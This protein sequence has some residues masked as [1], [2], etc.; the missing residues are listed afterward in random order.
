M[1]I[2]IEERVPHKHILRKINKVIDFDFIYNEVKGSYGMNGNVSVAP[3]VILKLMLLL[4]LYNVRSERELMETLSVRLDWLW[5]LKLDIDSEI[6]DHSVLS[7]ARTRWGVEVFKCLFERVVGQCVQAG[8]VNGKKLFVDASLIDAD[9]SNNSVIK[10]GSLKRYLRKGYRKLEDRLDELYEEKNGEANKK[11]ISTTDPDAAVTRHSSGESKLRYKTHRGVDAKSE[12]ITATIVTTGSVDDGEKLGD[13]I[14]EHEQT[15]GC[16][17]DTVVGDSKYG[18]KRN[19]LM[20]SELGIKAHMPNLEK[21][22]HGKGRKKG[23]YPKE[24][25]NYDAVTDTFTCP[26]GKKLHKRNFYKK[27]QH[28]EYKAPKGEC[29]Q[30]HLKKECTRAKDGRTVKRHIRQKDLDAMLNAALRP[31][32]IQD[33]KT[34]QHL[35]ERSFARSTRYGFKR[36]R[37]RGLWRM[38]I[39]DYLIA[40]VQNIQ[41]LLKETD[42]RVAVAVR[43][44]RRVDRKVR[45]LIR[46]SYSDNPLGCEYYGYV[47]Q[48]GHLMKSYFSP[49]LY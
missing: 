11:Y 25:F 36:A 22:H 9:A 27:R 1:D 8:L 35:S 5:F 3:P 45:A 39:Q 46:D 10:R 43:K 16:K 12:V 4:V 13:V 30:C 26:A 31:E 33:L 42:R 7:K 14:D 32:A 38:Q 28:Y 2:N 37:W 18:T 47:P 19:F 44:I 41:T 15:S 6:P 40:A 34:R 49:N 20:S 48:I 21:S 29:A 17:L 24:L 23:I